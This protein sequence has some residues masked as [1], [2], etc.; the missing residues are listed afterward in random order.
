MTWPAWTWPGLPPASRDA[1][2][3]ARASGGW[4]LEVGGKVYRIHHPGEAW[5]DEFLIRTNKAEVRAAIAGPR[6]DLEWK[7]SSEW[8]RPRTPRRIWKEDGW[9]KTRR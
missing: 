2:A 4:F 6:L 5:D 7:P 9:E 8:N 1:A 3:T